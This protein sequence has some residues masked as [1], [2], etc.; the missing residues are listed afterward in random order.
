VDRRNFDLG[1]RVRLLI[2]TGTTPWMSLPC[3]SKYGWGVTFTVT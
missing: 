1:A 3:R 2:V